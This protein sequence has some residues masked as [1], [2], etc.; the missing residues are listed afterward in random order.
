MMFNSTDKALV[1]LEKKINTQYTKAAKEAQKKAKAKLKDYEKKLK[2]YDKDLKKG[3]ITQEKYDAWKNYQAYQNKIVTDLADVLAKDASNS[4]VIAASIINDS[5]IDVYALNANETLYKIEKVAQ[6]KTSYTLYDHKTVENLITKNP[7]LYPIAAKVNVPKSDLWNKRK[8]NEALTQGI[9]QGESV[10]MLSK[11]IG[12]VYEMNRKASTRTARTMVTSA[13]NLGRVDTFKKADQM[14]IP[15]VQIWMAALDGRTRHSHRMLDGQR[16]DVGDP[17]QSMYGSIEYPGDP[18]ADPRD[19]YNCRCTLIAQVKGFEYDLEDVANRENK[20]DEKSYEEW[21]FEKSKDKDV[22]VLN[23][24]FINKQYELSKVEI[25]NYQGIWLHD[26][27]TTNWTPELQ[28]K[29]EKKKEYYEDQLQFIKSTGLHPEKVQEF[30]NH[31]K[32]LDELS[33]EGKK[34]YELSKELDGVN[35]ELKGLKKATGS[36]HFDEIFYTQDAK[37][38]ARNFFDKYEADL[39]H[40]AN[41]DEVWDTLDDSQKYAVWEY[42][43]NSNPM[44]KSL[45]GYH[46]TWSRRDF[47]GWANTDWGHEDNW[48]SIPSQFAQFGESGHV[49]YH[50][51][52]TDLTNAIEKSEL[53]EAA[54]FVRGSDAGG[55]AGIIADGFSGI[56]F[57]DIQKIIQSGDVDKLNALLEGQTFYNHAFTS[58]GIARGTG[59]SGE[60]SYEIYAPAGTKGIY[61][62][63]QSYFG[64]TVGSR[65]KLYK[66]GQ[67]YSDVGNEA[68]VIFQR[69]TGYRITGIKQADYGGGIKVQM[70]IVDQPDY[71][72][73][74]DEN[75]IDRGATRHRN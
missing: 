73:F 41:L 44:N 31:L 63:P 24:K 64:R 65:A 29:I 1:S 33:K 75:T 42:T 69:G 68:E 15:L 51:A 35:K 37:D 74:G 61:A 2:K 12:K 10:P 59:F 60:V 4:N 52:V 8:M 39:F 16:R 17:F 62:E 47:I 20:L 9:L 19:V 28:S 5:A 38:A 56:E 46:D 30:E 7:D 71:F 27:N 58:V 14:G 6:F 48:R 67:S 54:F 72:Q 3:V 40:R 50:K 43:Q 70:E 53:K 57:D 13:Q 32:E 49:K 22:D 55:F 21:K 36:G 18:H 23:N 45:S 11:R 25:K 34:Y 26:V 66:K